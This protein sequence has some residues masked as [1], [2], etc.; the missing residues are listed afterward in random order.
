MKEAGS[1]KTCVGCGAEISPGLRYC[2]VCYKPVSSELA[3]GVHKIAA[4]ELG[5]AR[6]IDP[7]V[8][9]LPE[10]HEAIARRRARRRRLII[11]GGLGVLLIV[12]ASAAFLLTGRDG[13]ARRR[14]LA[15]EDMARRELSLLADA[16]ERFKLD[17][18]R[19]PT[20]QEGIQS[21]TRRPLSDLNSWTGPYVDGV[22][23]VD[24]WGSDYM[25]RSVEGGDGFELFSYG[26]S[27][28]A[29]GRVH[30]VIRSSR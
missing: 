20:E 19:Y 8:V 3:A 25:Y 2:V 11:S 15:R 16:I 6:R 14:Q 17:V 29:T 21:L 24:P 22:Y 26:P 9:F 18:G 4:G 28:E 13:E 7:T 23:E 10:E 30:L 27:G 5:T 12:V 1:Q